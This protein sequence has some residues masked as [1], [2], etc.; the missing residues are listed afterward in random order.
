MDKQAVSVI[1]HRLDEISKSIQYLK[2]GF[3]NRLIQ[4]QQ[5]GF[6]NQRKEREEQR[7]EEHIQE[8]KK[9]NEYLKRQNTL[10]KWTLI[11]TGI[12]AIGQLLFNI[13]IEVFKL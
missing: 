9:Q 4:A 3:R 11:I 13:Y 10:L 7:E 1:A 12:A 2:P 6:E 8:I 5:E